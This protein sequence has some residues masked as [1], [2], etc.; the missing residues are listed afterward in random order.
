MAARKAQFG[1]EEIVET[2]FEMVRKD[3]W[4]GMSVPAVA[5]AINSSTMPVYSHF[6]NVGD[7]QDAV[8]LR[9]V[10]CMMEFQNVERTGDRWL[11]HAVGYVEFAR[12][13]EQLFRC[14]YDGRNLEL[15]KDAM[16]KWN[17]LMLE[18]L[19]DYPLF[20]GL[21]E[22]HV[23]IIRVSRYMLVHGMASNLSGWDRLKEQDVG[24]AFLKKTT[25]ALYDGLIIHF[26]AEK[27][28]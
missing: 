21:S 16:A 4:K 12:N 27:N 19:S 6:K 28:E 10:E 11:D 24:I 17:E 3:G 7:L 2:A 26:E 9:A 15:Q 23:R 25:Q 13:E 5:K 18:Q 22:D 8:Y 1:R 14:L 20:E